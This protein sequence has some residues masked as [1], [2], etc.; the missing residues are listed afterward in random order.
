MY[1]PALIFDKMKSHVFEGR[2]CSQGMN[3]IDRK[4]WGVVYRAIKVPKENMKYFKLL[5]EI[6]LT[7]YSV[8]SSMLRLYRIFFH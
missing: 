4:F 5:E 6:E 1:I 3:E 8:G 7:R 2:K